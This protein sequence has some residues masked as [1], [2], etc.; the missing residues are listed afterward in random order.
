MLAGVSND[1]Y[2]RLEQG[3]ERHPSD[4]VLAALVRALNLGPEA[5]AH[6]YELARPRASR[7]GLGDRSDEVHPNVVRLIQ[8]WDHAPA[9]VVN[10]RLDVL[11]KNPLATVL[12]E[13]L[14]HNDNLLRL[15]LLNPAAREFYP[16]WEWDTRSKVAHLRAVAGRDCTDPFML[17]LIEELSDESE[18]FRQMWDRYDVQA[19]TRTTV[20]FHHHRAGGLLTSMEVLS[21][22]SSPGQKLIIFQAEPGSPSDAALTL[23]GST[24]HQ[25]T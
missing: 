20:R 3:R 11:V 7:H 23:L 12:Y 5:A 22:D 10:Q 8:S 14:E 16:D 4:Q 1:Y 2:I 24:A 17:E 13:G 25:D 9:Y 19:R 18:E 15:A 21:I 6:L